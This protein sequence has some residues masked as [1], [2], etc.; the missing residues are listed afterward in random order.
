MLIEGGCFFEAEHLFN[1]HH[2]LPHIS[3]ITIF[4]QPVY[5]QKRKKNTTLNLILRYFLVC[6]CVWCG[7][8]GGGGASS[9]LDAY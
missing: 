3:N 8:G 5:Q 6:V 4:H 2:F 7:G 1:F 9:R